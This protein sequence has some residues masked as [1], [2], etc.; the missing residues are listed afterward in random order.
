[1]GYDMT[2]PYVLS[3]LIILATIIGIILKNTIG[4]YLAY[5]IPFLIFFPASL[6]LFR[7]E[8]TLIKNHLLNHIKKQQ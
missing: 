3:V 7:N 1:M 2:A 8:I 6:F 5:S 4:Y